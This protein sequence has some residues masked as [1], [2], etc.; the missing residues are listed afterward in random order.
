MNPGSLID[1]DRYDL[2]DPSLAERCH[3]QFADEGVCILA[4]FLRADVLP[5][6]VDECRA[7]EPLAFHSRS[8]ST[9]YLTQPDETLP[10]GHPGRR[11]VHSS[12]EVV[13]YDLFPT[14]SLLRALYEWDPL[15]DFVRRCLGLDQLHRYGDPFG[16]LNLSVMR[17]GDELC[18]HFDMA[19][20]VVSLAIQSSLVGGEFENAKQIRTSSDPNVDAVAAVLDDA[21]PALVRTEPMTPGTLM[22]FNGR[23][24]M[25]RVTTIRGSESR[26]VALLAYDT[27][28][29]TDSSPELKL[30]RYGRLPGERV[31]S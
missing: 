4:G 31:P 21:A 3:R 23:W 7:L 5:S 9:P 18:W 15:T 14:L 26:Y 25:H 10:I 6:L 13:A 29:G 11:L 17:E 12:V 22:L 1:T 2:A 30:S 19:D 28:P 27:E 8:S 16:A 24:S 20:F